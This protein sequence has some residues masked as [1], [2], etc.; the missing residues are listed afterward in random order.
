MN[1]LLLTPATWCI[2]LNFGGTMSFHIPV[3]SRLFPSGGNPIHLESQLGSQLG[4]Q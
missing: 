2:F 1:W 4:I 3:D